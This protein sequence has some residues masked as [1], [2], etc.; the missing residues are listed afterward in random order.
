MTDRD[1]VYLPES[2]HN[3][4]GEVFLLKDK[5]GVAGESADSGSG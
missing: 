3:F 5:V 1:A 2:L 4:Q